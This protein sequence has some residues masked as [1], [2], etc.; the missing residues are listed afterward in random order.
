M[1]RTVYFKSIK[2]GDPKKGRNKFVYVIIHDAYTDELM[3]SCLMDYA[4]TRIAEDNWTVVPARIEHKNHK[5]T[6][7]C[8]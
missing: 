1:S 8:S 3:L 7:A 4:L 2:T 5:S 6:L